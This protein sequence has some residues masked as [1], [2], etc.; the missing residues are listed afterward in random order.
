LQCVSAF[1]K[2]TLVE[3]ELIFY[4]PSFEGPLSNLYHLLK[5]EEM[6]ILEIQLSKLTEQCLQYVEK[7]ELF[8]GGGEMVLFITYLLL[9][10]STSLL[11]VKLEENSIIAEE[12]PSELFSQFIELMRFKEIAVDLVELEKKQHLFLPREIH[13]FPDKTGAG[14]EEVSLEELAALF[15]KMVPPPEEIEISEEFEI[16]AILEWFSQYIEEKKKV[17][18]LDIFS[19]EKKRGE[20]IVL[21]LAILELVKGQKLRVIKEEDT[22]FI[23]AL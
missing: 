12:G 6:D 3:K 23:C 11:P 4:L 9:M 14:L 21:F 2:N 8:Q 10:K 1:K 19:E 22:I 16:T 5:K 13:F 20:L 15:Q 17:L 18:F 7:K